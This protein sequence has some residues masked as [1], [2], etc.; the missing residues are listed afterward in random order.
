MNLIKRP[1]EKILRITLSLLLL[2]TAAGLF[3][4]QPAVSSVAGGFSRVEADSGYTFTWKIVG[5]EI[6]AT[7]SA[8]TTG[9]VAVGFNPTNKMQ[10]AT[11]VIGYVKD[12]TAQLR[13]DWGHSPIGHRAV[14]D[15]GGVSRVTLISGRE[16][17]G[18]TE[19]SFRLPLN[20]GDQY[21]TPIKA[22]ER[23]TVIWAFGSNNGDNYTAKHTKRGSLVLNF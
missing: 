15:M 11:Y 19:L 5:N 8:P 2:F 1:V 17:N 7:M 18:R 6:E 20:P 16:E 22:G 3:A 9:W 23:N 12:G 13:H 4:Q 10:G 14:T 21:F